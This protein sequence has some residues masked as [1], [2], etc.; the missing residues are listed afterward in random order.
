MCLKSHFPW[1]PKFWGCHFAVLILLFEI[2]FIILFSKIINA[3]AR[4]IQMKDKMPL[5]G[6]YIEL[7]Q[8]SQYGHGFKKR[9][10][11]SPRTNLQALLQRESKHTRYCKRDNETFTSV[12]LKTFHIDSL[13]SRIKWSLFLKWA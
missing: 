12:T 5:W 8:R 10:I 7:H 13:P 6:P 1:F 11:L 2:L 3:V 9:Y 4:D